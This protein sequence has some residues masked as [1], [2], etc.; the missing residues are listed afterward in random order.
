MTSRILPV[1][2]ISR[3]KERRIGM[4]SRI[5]LVLEISEEL[6]PAF[7]TPLEMEENPHPNLRR[8][9]QDAE[10]KNIMFFSLKR[11]WLD[12]RRHNAVLD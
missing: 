4:T 5:L 8:A 2:E 1:L 6:A 9:N 12:M 7:V 10:K 3:K 11:G